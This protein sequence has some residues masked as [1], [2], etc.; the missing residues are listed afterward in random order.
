VAVATYYDVLGVPQNAN[1]EDLRR[2]YLGLARTLHPDHT[3]GMAP[4]DAEVTA[5][6]MQQ[7]NEAWRI[8]RDPAS[9]AAYDRALASSGIRM[10]KLNVP[11][12]AARPRVE[13]PDF[14]TPFQHTP[15]RPGDI[16]VSVARLVPWI[17]IAVVLIAIFVFTAFAGPK[18][19]AATPQDYVGQCVSSASGSDIVQVPCEG[20][21]DG[22]VV[23]VANTPSACPAGSASRVVTSTSYLCLQPAHPIPTYTAT[24]AKP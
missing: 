12:P 20:P 21:N 23:L 18:H 8:L 5:R 13:E 22:K 14:D 4:T 2:A 1:N 24:T 17:S 15:A 19:K 16:G 9:R 7:V 10:P 11:R 3:H 6:K